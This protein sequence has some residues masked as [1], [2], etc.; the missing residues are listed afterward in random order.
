MSIGA[1][2]LSKRVVPF[3]PGSITMSLKLSKNSRPTTTVRR[4]VSYAYYSFKHTLQ[5]ALSRQEVD[6]WSW[7]GFRNRHRHQEA[8]KRKMKIL[9][10]IATN[11]ATLTLDTDE[12]YK[13]TVKTNSK[14][15]EVENIIVSIL[16]N[17]INGGYLNLGL[18][19]ILLDLVRTQTYVT[20]I[21]LYSTFCYT[22]QVSIYANNFFGARH[23]LETLSQLTAYHKG[24]NSIQIIDDV[25]IDDKPAYPYR[26]VL[27][28]TSRNYYSV[29]SI[30]RVIKAMSYN[31]LN[32]FHWHLT[33]THSFP[34]YIEGIPELTEYG[35]YSRTKVCNQ[36]WW[37]IIKH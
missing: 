2:K 21:F 27:L 25:S 3:L 1:T 14:S 31:K 26:G 37:W 33:D 13:L 28:D 6:A 19:I 17:F 36:L 30:K 4:L 32:T 15:I 7:Q 23:A 5:Y 18:R 9:I 10:V 35:A 11:E 12:S 22:Q 16:M 20:L 24:Y 8:S 29:D 34:L